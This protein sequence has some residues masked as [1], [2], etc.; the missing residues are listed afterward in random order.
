MNASH[1]GMR[2]WTVSVEEAGGKMCW[3]AARDASTWIVAIA[4]ASLRMAF[5]MVRFIRQ[6]PCAG[7]T[8]ARATIK[9]NA[10]LSSRTPDDLHDS[11]LGKAEVAADQPVGQPVAVHG[12]HA[13][14]L[15][16]RRPLA[17]LAAQDNA[18]GL[19]GGQT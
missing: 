2:S 16:V 12:E 8:H 6:V 7:S 13:L 5:R 3:Y 18:A 11:V 19:G 17:D 15:L 1:T 14:G 9:P 10:N 4:S